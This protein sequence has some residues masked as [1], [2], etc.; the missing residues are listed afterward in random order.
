MSDSK[1]P[2]HTSTTYLTSLLIGTADLLLARIYPSLRPYLPKSTS[3][4]Q[5]KTAIITGANSGIGLQIAKDLAQL[6]ATVTLGCRNLTKGQQAVDEIL[7]LT[8]EARGRVLLRELD[9]SK[10]ESVRE[11]ARTCTEDLKRNGEV[12]RKVD[13]LVN[14]AG[15]GSLPPGAKSEFSVDGNEMI[16]ATNFLGSFLLTHLLE[17]KLAEDARVI[18]TSSFGQYGGKFAPGFSTSP[19]KE[20]VETGFHVIGSGDYGRVAT[21]YGMTKSMQTAFAR[22]LQQKWDREG[23]VAGHVN[24]RVAHAFTPGYTSTEIFGKYEVQNVWKEPVF[25]ALKAWTVIATH[26]SEGAATG[27]WLASTDDKQVVGTGMGGGY[28]DR[29]IR[30]T[31]TADMFGQEMLDRLWARWEADAGIE[32]R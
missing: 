30:R 15:I 24:R 1:A 4:L 8:P 12:G 10:M 32:W 14:N 17:D 2:A 6:G 21:R 31:S 7:S 22:S 11:F 16:Y 25:A 3:H 26:V 29:M 28:W 18:F 9:T 5:S 20:R 23:A 19:V 13:I 27:T